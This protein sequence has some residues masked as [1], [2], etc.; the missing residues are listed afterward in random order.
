MVLPWLMKAISCTRVVIVSMLQELC[1]QSIT[2]LSKLN[3]VI[4]RIV[5]I[6]LIELKIQRS[7]GILLACASRIAWRAR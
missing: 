6:E 1:S 4:N 5:G 7:G 3:G 2:E